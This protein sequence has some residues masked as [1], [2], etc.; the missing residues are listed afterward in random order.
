MKKNGPKRVAHFYPS[1]DTCVVFVAAHPFVRLDEIHLNGDRFMVDEVVDECHVRVRR[2]RL[3]DKLRF[4]R[5]NT[6]KAVRRWW[7]NQFSGL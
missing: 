6:F 1:E 5:I 7:F 4:A 2:P 3:L